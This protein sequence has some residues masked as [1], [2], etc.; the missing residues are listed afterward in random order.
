MSLDDYW[1]CDMAVIKIKTTEDLFTDDDII[2]DGDEDSYYHKDGLYFLPDK[3][4][5]KVFVNAEEDFLNSTA[6]GY[7]DTGHVIQYLVNYITSDKISIE[8]WMIDFGHK[9]KLM[10]LEDIIDGI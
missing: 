10:T 2:Y 1:D 5:G 9:K 4:A 8:E 3:L 6:L 7:Y